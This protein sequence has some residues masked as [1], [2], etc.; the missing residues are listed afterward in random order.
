MLLA[1]AE[2]P[3]EGHCAPSGHTKVTLIVMIDWEFFIKTLGV[4]LTYGFFVKL[5]FAFGTSWVCL[6]A[7]SAKMRIK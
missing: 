5:P 4:A 6:V 3:Q 1:L 2:S 7:M